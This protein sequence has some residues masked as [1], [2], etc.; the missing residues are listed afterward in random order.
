M[1]LQIRARAAHRMG[2]CG[3]FS[4]KS[5]AG[6]LGLAFGR[7]H[8]PSQPRAK[9]C[10]LHIAA[11]IVILV[12]IRWVLERSPLARTVCLLFVILFALLCGLHFSGVDHSDPGGLGLADLVGIS[13]FFG[14]LLN[15]TRARLR[16][17]KPRIS[18]PSR[19][20]CAWRI[21]PRAM[22]MLVPT[23]SP[24]RC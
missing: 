9:P 8:E 16:S 20:A 2:T 17:S 13:L 23:G 4:E 15:V 14:L 24:L 12:K 11:G 22:S 1:A 6:W 21:P 7:S 3:V 18:A 5:G 19:S 10:R